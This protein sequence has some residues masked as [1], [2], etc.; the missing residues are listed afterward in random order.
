MPRDGF[1]KRPAAF[2]MG[3]RP[4]DAVVEQFLFAARKVFRPLLFGQAE[5]FSKQFGYVPHASLFA[6]PKTFEKGQHDGLKIGNWHNYLVITLQAVRYHATGQCER[7]SLSISSSWY[8]QTLP[9]GPYQR[10]RPTQLTLPSRKG[11]CSTWRS[12]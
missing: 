6:V 9:Q 4:G 10:Q 7:E 2:K 3:L 8:F 1:S 5:S 12:N 11:P